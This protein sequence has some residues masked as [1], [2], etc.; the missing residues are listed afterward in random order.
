MAITDWP[1]QE[2]PREKLLA[3]GPASL[4]DSE[5]LAIFLRTGV[6]GAS[7]V[8]VSR[9]LL[10]HFGSLRVL[11][12][13]SLDKYDHVKGVGPAKYVLLQ[14]ALEVGRRYLQES[15]EKE[16]V[17]TSPQDAKRFLLAKMRHHPQEVFSGLF[18][19]SQHRLIAYEELFYGTIDGAS[20]YPREV[21]RK[22]I[23]LNAAAV[24][25]AHNHPSGVAE[26]SQADIQITGRLVDALSLVDARVL[27]H[28]V[29]GDTDVVS[30]AE[31]GLI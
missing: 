20:V 9:Q 29:V 14:A 11:L 12:D 22:V 18:L 15:L 25:F 10:Q 24:I 21:V 31:R 23:D 16:L 19:D 30:L 13:A 7:A 1:E 8:D 3:R 2:R 5:L 17:L 4:S 26:P 28:M 6:S 27:D